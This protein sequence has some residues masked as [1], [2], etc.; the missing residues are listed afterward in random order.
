MT[1]QEKQEAIAKSKEE[2]GERHPTVKN[3]LELLCASG[4]VC[5]NA[6][7]MAVYDNEAFVKR[8][9]EEGG[10]DTIKCILAFLHSTIGCAES[11]INIELGKGKM[12]AIMLEA[13]MQKRM[14]SKSKEKS[15]GNDGSKA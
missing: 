15:D 11:L 7:H 10:A 8:L 5:V 6:L 13:E 1:E 3:L 9:Q 14:S 4:L 12:F 2:S